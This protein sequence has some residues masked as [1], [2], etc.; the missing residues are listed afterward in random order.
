MF[1]HT[2]SLLLFFKKIRV[3]TRNKLKKINL[4][5]Q[6]PKKILNPKNYEKNNFNV[7]PSF[8]VYYLW[9]I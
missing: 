9:T 3:P 1:A 4:I 7:V 2:V 6:K 8:L 5:P